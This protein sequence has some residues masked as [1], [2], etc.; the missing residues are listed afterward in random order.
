MYAERVLHFF[1]DQLKLEKFID[2]EEA[3][4]IVN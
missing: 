3:Q 4:G 2:V 1:A